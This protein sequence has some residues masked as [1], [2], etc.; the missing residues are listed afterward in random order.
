[1]S[2]FFSIALTATGF[3]LISLFSVKFVHAT[4]SHFHPIIIHQFQPM[5]HPFPYQHLGMLRLYI[6][7]IGSITIHIVNPETCSRD[8]KNNGFNSNI[9][10]FYYFYL[11]PLLIPPLGL[12]REQLNG[13]GNVF[14]G[15]NIP[16]NYG[17]N[18]NI[19]SF[20]YFLY[21]IHL[22][23]IPRDAKFADKQRNDSSHQA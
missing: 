23:P 3:T 7:G 14:I 4:R 18:Y 1:M 5:C 21:A 13:I 8:S 19:C 17:F 11:S 12:L 22:P 9:G 16:I 10:C 20:C 15:I 2:L 6:N